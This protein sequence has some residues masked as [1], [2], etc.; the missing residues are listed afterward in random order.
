METQKDVYVHLIKRARHDRGLTQ[1]ELAGRAG[2]QQST[3]AALES[4]RRRLTPET[5][6]RILR[7]VELR[8]SVMLEVFRDSVVEKAAEHGFIELR[9][10]GSSVH[11]TDTPESDIDLIA[12]FPDGASLLDLAAAITDVSAILGFPVDI[13]EDAEPSDDPVKR[14][15]LAEAVPL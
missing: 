4:G 2:M 7:A 15:I 12:C 5:R 6:A 3:L 14:R 1:A 11:G 10:F 13:I 8:P 9:V